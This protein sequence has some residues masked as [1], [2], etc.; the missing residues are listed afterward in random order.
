MAALLKKGLAE[1]KS[2]DCLPKGGGRG[3]DKPLLGGRRAS[4]E[5][6]LSWLQD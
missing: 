3:F 5:K 1:Q 2:E 6:K 4:E